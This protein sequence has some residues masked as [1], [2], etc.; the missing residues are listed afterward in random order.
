VDQP[1]GT[2]STNIVLEK[3]TVKVPSEMELNGVLSEPLNVI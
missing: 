2:F 1:D 3:L